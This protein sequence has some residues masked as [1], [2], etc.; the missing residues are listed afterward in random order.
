MHL[1]PKN[2][3]RASVCTNGCFPPKLTVGAG[4]MRTTSR[5]GPPPPG[6]A[7]CPC[8]LVPDPRATP[9]SAAAGTRALV[10]HD[11]SIHHSRL[12]CSEAADMGPVG[13]ATRTRGRPLLYCRVQRPFPRAPLVEDSGWLP[14]SQLGCPQPAGS[15][16]GDRPTAA[17]VPSWSPDTRGPVRLSFPGLL[18]TPASPQMEVTVR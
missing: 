12:W 7:Q 6:T 3:R 1:R 11:G 2:R 8:E 18:A 14:V 9:T 4:W 16:Q 13:V 17:I 15:G 10:A 5:C